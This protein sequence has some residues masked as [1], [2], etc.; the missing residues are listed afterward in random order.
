MNAIV[1][2]DNRQGMLFNHRRQSRDQALKD[3][4]LNLAGE[5][6]LHMNHFSEKLFEGSPNIHIAEDFLDCARE[7]DFCFVED[8]LLKPYENKIHSLIVCRW[9]RDY[10]G[11]F[12]L[13]LDYSGRKL[14]FAEEFPGTSHEKI[15]VE[16]Y[17]K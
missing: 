14:V 16:V 4:L 13:D 8:H 10:P 12:F 6:G 7:D 5:K 11:D 1:C 15:T 9:N 2:V 3:F 17:V